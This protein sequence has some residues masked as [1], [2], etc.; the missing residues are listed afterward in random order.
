MSFS[1]LLLHLAGATTLLI[2]AVRMVRTGVERGHGNALRRLLRRA[3]G[4][5]MQEVGAGTLIALL[6]QSSTAVA[7]LAAGFATSGI[8]ATGT[9]LA[10]MLGAD[11]GSALVVQILSFDLDWLI[12]VLMVLGGGLFLQGARP[13]VRQTG[14]VLMGIALILLSLRLIGEATE[15]LRDS[16]MLPAV[17][18]YLKSDYITAFLIGAVF[19]WLLHSSVAAI[20]LFMT[21]ALQAGIPVELG[22]SLML[23]ANVGGG[24]IAVGLTQ[25][26]AVEARRITLGN[27][28]FRAVAAVTALLAVHNFDL[29]IHLAGADVA[30]QIVNLHLGFNLALVLFCAPLTGLMTG[31]VERILPDAPADDTDMRAERVSALDRSVM[32]S[33]VRALACTTRELLRVGDMLEL[34][35]KPVMELYE[36]GDPER[37]R[38]VQKMDK[39]VNRAH[40]EIKLYLAEMTGKEMRRKDAERSMELANFAISLEHVGD[41]ISRGL[42]PLAQERADRK[43]QFSPE[44]WNELTDLHDRVTANM[45]LAMN[46]LVSGDYDSARRLVEE[47]E[48]MRELE[49]QSHQRHLA[50][51][52]TRSEQSLETSGIHLETIRALKEINSLVTTVA[53]PILAEAGEL[54][55]SRLAERG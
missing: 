39:D 10:M 18:A 22:V 34:M 24:L 11:L 12:P 19:T 41:I 4:N 48:R 55:D 37:I 15:P 40:S 9:G 43:L 52:Q 2:W 20:L 3:R 14:R 1:L 17:F 44:G 53:Y 38:Q 21:L 5:L 49:R 50:R 32:N 16:E 51:L 31:L 36:S 30:R 13:E 7:M 33:P 26:S 23:G 42:M 28:I 35:L 6:L 29:P 25:A 8:L 54:L 46:V 27:L 47:K 45:K